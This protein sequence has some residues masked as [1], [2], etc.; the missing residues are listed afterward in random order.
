MNFDKRVCFLDTIF[1]QE[2]DGEMVLLDLN[3]ENYYG[4]DSV[5]T[6]IWRILK[7]GKTLNECA[8]EMAELY[9]VE[10]DRIKR[11]LEIF[12]DKLLED[13]LAELC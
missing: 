1:A 13:G 9:G 6:D 8:N 2:V 12:V 4:L 3:S 10:I 7:E 11:D 5:A